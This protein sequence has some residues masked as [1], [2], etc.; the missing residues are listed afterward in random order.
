MPFVSQTETFMTLLQICK[1]KLIE[2]EWRIYAAIIYQYW[3]RKW[4]APGRHQA[5]IGTNAAILLVEN[6][7]EPTAVKS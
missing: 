5:I 7:L 3:F 6:F 4:R 2:A 1:I